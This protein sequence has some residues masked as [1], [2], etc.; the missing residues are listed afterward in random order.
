SRFTRAMA[1]GSSFEDANLAAATFSHAR[2]EGASFAR[3]NLVGVSFY[4]VQAQGADFNRADLTAAALLQSQVQGTN[5]QSA[6]FP[7]ATF[8]QANL[9]RSFV[10]IEGSAN[11]ILIMVRA[12]D[13]FPRVDTSGIRSIMAR[14][15]SGPEPTKLDNEGYTRLVSRALE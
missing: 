6:K 8:N 9:F 2:L 15:S 10:K 7:Y 11:A 4:A 13:R 12:D 14:S 1:Q 5:F 3:A